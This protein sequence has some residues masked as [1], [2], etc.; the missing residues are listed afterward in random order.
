[1]PLLLLYGG[2]FDPVHNGHLA[3]ARAA[4]DRLRCW[5]HLMPAADPPHRSAPG[6]SASERVQMLERAVQDEPGLVVDRRELERPGPSYTVDT[7]RE[8]REQVGRQM[9]LALLLGSDSFLSLPGWHDWQALFGLAH[10]VVAERAGASLDSQLPET[11]AQTIAGRWS[12]AADVLQRSPAGRVLRLQQPL[13]PVSA[14]DVRQRL[15]TGTEWTELLPPTVAAY[16][17]EHGLY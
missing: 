9:P 11:L 13:V 4:R 2:T 7:L 6:A 3:V 16:I 5:V 10:L 17:R 15:A 12:N 14:S 8:L 1:M